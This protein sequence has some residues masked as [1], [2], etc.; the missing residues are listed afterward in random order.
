M[1]RGGIAAT[2]RRDGHCIIAAEFRIDFPKPPRKRRILFCAAREI[3]CR[4]SSR[5]RFR[6]QMRMIFLWLGFWLITGAKTYKIFLNMDVSGGVTGIP[7]CRSCGACGSVIGLRPPPPHAD[8]LKG[9]EERASAL[10]R[11][12]IPLTGSGGRM[13][14]CSWHE[15]DLQAQMPTFAYRSRAERALTR[16]SAALCPGGR[17]RYW[18]S[19]MICA[20]R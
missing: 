14:G 15:S 10:T 12:P 11:D 4:C 13:N 18:G 19:D 8:C 17:A 7:L 1:S 20:Q 6:V 9:S 2:L 3:R 16:R 5:K